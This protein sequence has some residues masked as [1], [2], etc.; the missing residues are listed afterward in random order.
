MRRETTITCRPNDYHVGDVIA[1]P[2]KD[3]ME[4]HHV[5][6]VRYGGKLTIRPVA[7]YKYLWYRLQDWWIT[8]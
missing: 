6:R 7:W 3:G 4:Y 5:T 2:G 1:F 8:L